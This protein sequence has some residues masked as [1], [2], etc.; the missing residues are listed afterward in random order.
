MSYKADGSLSDF[1]GD[2]PM[3][4]AAHR[5]VERVG[6]E[7]RERVRSHTPIAK[8]PNAAV[9]GEWLTERKRAP[10]TLRESW[11]IGEVVVVG[12][13]GRMSIDVYTED[14]IAPDVEWETQPH[15]IVAKGKAGGGM[16]RYWDKAGATVFARIVHH[17]GTRGVHMMAT[18]LVEVAVSWQE[19]GKDEIERWSREQLRG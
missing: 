13:S 3:E 1:F 9:A 10:G 17:P 15:L 19:I 2:A 8:P 18:T 11:K 16:L 14:P 5:T 4:R 7:M 6:K 12:S